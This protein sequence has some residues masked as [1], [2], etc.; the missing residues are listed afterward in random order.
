MATLKK[1][2]EKFSTR[3]PRTARE[4]MGFPVR[5]DTI[6]RIKR[7][8]ISHKDPTLEL[9]EHPEKYVRREGKE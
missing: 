7:V 5:M 3:Q 2:I 6:L 1:F 9:L 8:P 4:F